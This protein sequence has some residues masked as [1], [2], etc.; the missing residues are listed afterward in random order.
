MKKIALMTW[1]HTENYGTAFQAYAL[2]I[3]IEKQGCSVD[4]IDYRR[5]NDA[6]LDLPRFSQRI[7]Y[8]FHCFIAFLF[9]EKN[10]RFIFEKEVFGR[11]Y[12]D[13]FT[14]TKR[15]LYNQDFADLNSH[16][17]GFVCGSDQIWGPSWYDG[18]FF[19]DFV[20]NPQ[21]LISY[22]PSLGVPVIRH[23]Q[24]RE[25]MKKLINRFPHISLREKTG[26]D[27]IKNLIQRE[28]VYNVLDPVLMIDSDYWQTLEEPFEC[29]RKYALIFFLA[30]NKRNILKSVNAAK[31]K[32]LFPI[33]LHCTQT[34][35][36]PFANTPGLTPGQLL[37]CVRN[38]SLVCTDSFHVVVL[39]ILYHKQF[40]SFKKQVGR[41]SE[42]QYKRITDL[43]NRL[44][45][46]GGVF[47]DDASFN[48]TI[49]YNNVDSVLE[50]QRLDSLIYLKTA[51]N[52]LPN[53]ID[54]Y[55]EFCEINEPCKGEYTKAFADYISTIND[56]NKKE[57]AISC[58]FALDHKCY[59]CKY[60]ISSFGEDNRE[61]L[62]YDELQADLE[63][64]KKV[65]NR[66]YLPFYF[67][68]II[69]RGL[70]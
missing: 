35:D 63:N 16:Y 46:E 15:C 14:Y 59:R 3:L 36:T 11:F 25:Q 34:N 44:N 47:V 30:N 61:P 68:T 12:E 13:N 21:K 26:C 43:I 65:F 50:K 33:V 39:S 57:F 53:Q 70:R 67:S 31:E 42:S 40:L 2:K 49:D 20:N 27:E 56:I 64:K 32:N 1:H 7:L 17:D 29:D 10:R 62:F 5:L 8:F 48:Q 55:I 22:A 52:S 60:L 9:K 66:Y 19:L 58:Q 41:N 37:Y 4:L 54:K 23:P 18:R 51:L 38:S 45:I 69:K 28:D 24:I 6:P